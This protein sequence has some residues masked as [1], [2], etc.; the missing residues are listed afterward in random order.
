MTLNTI[1]DWKKL[2]SKTAN[3]FEEKKWTQITG[4]LA[5]YDDMTQRCFNG[6][7]LCNLGIDLS[8]L[9][10]LAVYGE[11]YYED[12]GHTTDVVDLGIKSIVCSLGHGHSPSFT[13]IPFYIGHLND[14]H[15]LK[16]KELQKQFDKDVNIAI[17]K[18]KGKKKK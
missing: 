7:M 10:D 16:G 2:V 5:A 14:I 4:E 9:D 6:G 18:S 11:D 13:E 1:N 8:K 3:M 15:E 12:Y 17:R